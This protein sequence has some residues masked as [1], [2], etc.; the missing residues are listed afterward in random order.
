M[1]HESSETI[2]HLKLQALFFPFLGIKIIAIF[3]CAQIVKV[4]ENIHPRS[5][6][7]T[8]F[9]RYVSHPG[10]CKLKLKHCFHYFNY[11]HSV[12]DCD[13]FSTKNGKITYRKYRKIY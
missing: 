6:Y 2:F 1:K 5:Q 3:L 8:I 13:F 4:K 11:F 10:L 12:F 7:V 9:K